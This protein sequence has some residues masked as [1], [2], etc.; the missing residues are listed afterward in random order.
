[1]NTTII[2]VFIVA[3]Y[4]GFGIAAIMS[5]GNEKTRGY[6]RHLPET[7]HQHP[8]KSVPGPARKELDRVDADSI[9]EAI[10]HG[11]DTQIY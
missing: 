2:I 10:K 6:T 9:H 11:E 3:F 7:D 8:P 1:M 5:A 4:L